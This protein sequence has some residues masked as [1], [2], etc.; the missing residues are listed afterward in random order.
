VSE[1][2]ERIALET[3]SR[4]PKSDA[5][6]VGGYAMNAYAPPRFSLDCDLVILGNPVP[7]ESELKNQ[8]FEKSSTGD[9][10]YGSYIRYELKSDKVSFDLLVNSLVDNRT[11]IAFEGKLF[12]KYSADRRTVGRLATTMVTMRI[13]DPELLL[14]TKFVPA[15][16]QDARD[17]FMLSG[18]DIKWDL[19][20]K[21]I[22]T[23]CPD[24][25]IK[26]SKKMIQEIVGS[27]QYRDSLQSAYGRIP[28][29]IFSRSR[30]NLGS[31]LE[32]L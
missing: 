13:V 29:V 25:V 3:L 9:V 22:R 10:P 4:L 30:R 17:I 20:E 11:M 19:V 26:S 16:R 18:T 24:A 31:F 8:G 1:S 15:R 32:R 2:R 12:D 5:V 21:L 6:L 14:A 27:V 7:I 28:D 23:K